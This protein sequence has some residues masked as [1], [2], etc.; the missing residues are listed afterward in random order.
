ME[1]ELIASSLPIFVAS[2]G[3]REGQHTIGILSELKML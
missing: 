2:L 3:V 1:R